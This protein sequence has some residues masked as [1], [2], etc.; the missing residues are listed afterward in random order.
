MNRRFISPREP[1]FALGT[2][3][4]LAT[5]AG[6]VVLGTAL[7]GCQ[8]PKPPAPAPA[9]GGAAAHDHDHGE[10][11]EH[12]GHLLHLEPSGSHAEWTHDDT[13]KLTIYL[14]EVAQFGKKIEAVKVQLDVKGQAP[15]VFEFKALDSSVFE[16]TSEELLKAIEMTGAKDA[17][18]T[19]KL[20]ATIDGKEE[21][22][23]VEHDDHGHHH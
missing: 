3:A 23:L 8:P 13:G 22:A 14:D 7:V 2:R 11:G 5:L 4:N 17:G 21:S 18:M 12:G 16:L 9:A 10:H 19:V 15:K 6:V 20:L 1:L